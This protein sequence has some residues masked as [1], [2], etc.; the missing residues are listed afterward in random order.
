MESPAEEQEPEHIV[1]KNTVR[2]MV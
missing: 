1:E 2:A